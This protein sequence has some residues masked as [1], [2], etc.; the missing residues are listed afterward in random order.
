MHMT[1]VFIVKQR[2]YISNIK[3]HK[4][5]ITELNYVKIVAVHI[6]SKPLTQTAIKN[7][8]RIFGDDIKQAHPQ[9]RGIWKC[10]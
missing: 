4:M 8:F 1:I 10:S 2:S 3:G 7:Q 9:V 5:A 6:C